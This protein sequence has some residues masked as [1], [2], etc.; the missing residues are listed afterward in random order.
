MARSLLHACY[1]SM[2]AQE[3]VAHIIS[4]LNQQLTV[5]KRQ[6]TRTDAA[7]DMS[8]T[9]S[10]PTLISAPSAQLAPENLAHR[11]LWQAVAKLDQLWLLVAGQ[12]FSAVRA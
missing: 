12:Q 9:V 8:T 1:T 4:H 7:G 3:N 6:R 11:R 2:T 5:F 10:A